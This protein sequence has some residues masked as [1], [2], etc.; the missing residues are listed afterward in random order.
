M[1]RLK[2]LLVN[3]SYVQRQII[4]VVLAV[5]VTFIGIFIGFASIHDTFYF[6]LAFVAG[7][8]FDQAF[9]DGS[10][11]LWD[12]TRLYQESGEFFWSLCPIFMGILSIVALILTL[13]GVK[14]GNKYY[15]LALG[16]AGFAHLIFALA[17]VGLVNHDFGITVVGFHISR[18]F[19]LVLSLLGSGFWFFACDALD[20]YESPQLSHVPEEPEND[21]EKLLFSLKEKISKVK[22]IRKCG[23]CGKILPSKGDICKGC[24]LPTVEKSNGCKGCGATLAPGAQFCPKCGTQT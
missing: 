1:H 2:T 24:G 9:G 20:V 21:F 14:K 16:G 12:M 3:V 11:N 5:F 23:H 22:S 18:V 19:V 4:T 13:Y 8:I 15:P 6:Y 17:Y 7:A 10:I